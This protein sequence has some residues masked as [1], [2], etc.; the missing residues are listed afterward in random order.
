VDDAR[1]ADETEDR[2]YGFAEGMRIQSGVKS[3][4]DGFSVEQ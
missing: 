4:R 2:E 3:L 1:L